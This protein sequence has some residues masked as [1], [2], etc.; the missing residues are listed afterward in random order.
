MALVTF[1]NATNIEASHLNTNFQDEEAAGIAAL[2]DK[3]PQIEYRLGVIDLG[4]GT[5]LVERSCIIRPSTY[6]FIEEVYYLLDDSGGTVPSVTATLEDLT[7]SRLYD[8]DELSDPT[9]FGS[10]PKEGVIGILGPAHSNTD[11]GGTN[12]GVLIPGHEYRLSLSSST[13]VDFAEVV[14]VGHAMRGRA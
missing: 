1:T 11:Q 8:S 2:K 3:Q 6:V 13:T 7:D 5:A 9:G 12:N 14:L 4:S 10:A